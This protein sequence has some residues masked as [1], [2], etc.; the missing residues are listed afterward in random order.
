MGSSFAATGHSVPCQHG[1]CW[2]E[3]AKHILLDVPFEHTQFIVN[4]GSSTSY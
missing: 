4:L 3:I 1:L 2:K